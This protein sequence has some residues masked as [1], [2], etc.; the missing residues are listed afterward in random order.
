MAKPANGQRGHRP[1]KRFGQ[2]FLHDLHVIQQIIMVIN[3]QANDVMV[4]IGPGLG[5]ITRYLLPEV[6]TL[7]VVELDRDVLGPLRD[8]CAGLGDLHCHQ[9]D[10]LAFDFRTLHPGPLRLVGNLPYN[11]S[12]PLIFHLLDYADIIQDMHFML[13]KEVVVRMAAQP[14][15]KD[16][17]RLSVMVQYYC[18]V[19]NLFEVGPEAFRPP[20][21]VDSAVVRLLP[22]RQLPHFAE[23]VAILQ[24]VVK[25]AFGQ[26][27]KTLSNSLKG[28]ISPEDLTDL[29]I[30][31]KARAEQLSVAEYVRIANS[32][33]NEK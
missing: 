28:L 16:Y 3:P 9:G 14:G 5:A 8:T 4:E 19:D 33:V 15:N 22:H 20:P 11:I 18:Q 30:D 6:Q 2:H 7:H 27:R 31:P 23:D 13:Q 32:L 24:Q 17:G 12:T 1:R 10:A 25:G 26:R 29:G 21:Q